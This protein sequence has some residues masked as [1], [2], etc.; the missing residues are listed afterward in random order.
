MLTGVFALL[1]GF[2]MF[3]GSVSLLFVFI[4]LFILFSFWEIKAIEEPE[5]VKRLGQEYIEY[6]EI[7]P[8]FFPNFGRIFKTVNKKH[9]IF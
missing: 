9:F 4:P 2:G 1:F 7:T 6:R 5:L 3:L 8:M